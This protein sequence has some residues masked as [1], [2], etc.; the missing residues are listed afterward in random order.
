[1]ETTKE[2][3]LMIIENFIDWYTT[4]EHEQIR[5]KEAAIQYVDGDHV[6]EIKQ[7]LDKTIYLTLKIK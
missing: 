3:K 7:L 2:I 6:D 5:M 1:M 4:D